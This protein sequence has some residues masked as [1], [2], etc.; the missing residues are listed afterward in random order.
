MKPWRA[1]LVA[2]LLAACEAEH[3]SADPARAA[4]AFVERLR[5][6]HGD[7]KQAM[8]AFELL[9]LS[10]QENLGERAKRASALAGRK[11][12]PEEMLVPSRLDL[13]FEPR[14][15]E[16]A[17]D[18]DWAVVTIHGDRRTAT[19]RCKRDAGAWRVVL[20]LPP[21]PPVEARAGAEKPEAK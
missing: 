5:R 13:A 10:T 7:P 9:D 12:G 20:Q 18:G 2:L 4:Q 16:A 17:I 8:A 14:R 11:L 19:L 1:L 15:Y 21:L 3:P 6:V